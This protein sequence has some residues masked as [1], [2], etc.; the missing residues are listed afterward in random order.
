MSGTMDIRLFSQR[1]FGEV[2][3][4]LS[5]PHL[6][7]SVTDDEGRNVAQIAVEEERGESATIH[8]PQPVVLLYTSTEQAVL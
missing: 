8:L 2:Q 1:Q 7:L 4:L 3:T 6:D 5:V